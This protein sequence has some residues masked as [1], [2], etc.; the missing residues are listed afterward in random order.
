MLGQHV[1][2]LGRLNGADRRLIEWGIEE[3]FKLRDM[4][5]DLY[6]KIKWK[7]TLHPTA[8]IDFLINEWIYVADSMFYQYE[9]IFAWLCHW[10]KPEVWAEI[11][12][13][14]FK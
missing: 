3:I 8:N 13:D 5:T 7:R 2:G 10:G 6:N 12:Y 4:Y 9:L 1:F 14:L 11:G